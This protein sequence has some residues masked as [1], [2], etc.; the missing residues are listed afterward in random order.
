MRLINIILLCFIVLFVSSCSD[1]KNYFIDQTK[2]VVNVD[3]KPKI[4]FKENVTQNLNNPIESSGEIIINKEKYIGKYIFTSANSLTLLPN[5]TFLPNNNYKITFDFEAINKIANANIKPKSFTMEFSTNYLELELTNADFI[6]DS[7]DLSKI[8]LDAIINISQIVPIQSLKDNIKLLNSKGKNIEINI[9]E[10]DNKAFQILS[11]PLNIPSKNETYKL[12]IDKSLGLVKN[13]SFDIVAKSIDGLDIIDIKPILDDN[14]SIEVRFSAPLKQNLNLNNFIKISPSVNFRVS[15]LNDKIIINGNFNKEQDYNLEILQGI[16][17]QDNLSLAKNYQKDIVFGSQEPKIVFSNN[18]VFLPDS[19][20]KKI[21]FKSINVKKAKVVVK[22]IYANNIIRYIESYS[23]LKN[24]T[25]SLYTYDFDYMGSIVKESDIDIDYKKNIWVQNE[26]DLSGIKDLSGIF[27]VS[28]HFDKDNVDYKF[29]SGTPEWKINDYF[30]NNGNVYR[31]L[32]FS[33]IA[34][35]AQKYGD[36][37]IVSALDIKTNSPLSNVIIDGISKNNQIISSSKTDKN[38]NAILKYKGSDELKKQEL[39]YIFAKKQDSSNDLALIKLS[40][41]RLPDDGFDTEGVNVDNGIKA[42]IYTDRGVYR[43]GDTIN[44]NIIARNNKESLKH[45]IKLTITNPR[46]KKQI[47]NVILEPISD[48]MFYYAFQTQKNA[49]TGIYNV[50]I[51]IG[52]NIFT[53]KIAL[54]SVVPNRIKVNIDS[55]NKIDLSQNS[56]I[57]LTLQSEYLFGA[58]ASNLEYNITASI[59]PKNFISKKYKD[60]SFDNQTNLR[61]VEN[62][63]FSGSLNENGYA[64]N[65]L[66]LKD[67][68]KIN[69]N[70]EANII[71]RVYENN[72]RQVSARKSVYIKRFDSFVGIKIPQTRYVQ[73]DDNINLNVVLLDE[74]ENHIANRKLEYTVYNNNYSWWWD[75]DNYNDYIRSIKTDK[76]TT[77]IAKGEITSKDSINNIRFKANA[78]GELLVEVRDTTNNQSASISLYA[79]SWGEPINADKITQLKIKSDKSKY[80]HNEEAVITFESTKNAKALVTISNNEEIIDRYFVDTNNIKTSINVKIDEKYAPNLYVS[81]FLLQ[82]YNTN[83]NDR[84]LRLYGVVPLNIINTK[85]KIDLNINASDE[86]LPNSTLD[87]E[88]SNNQNKQVTYTLAI[89]DEGIINLTNFKTPSPYD[90]FYAK[91]KYPIINY[92]TFDYIIGRIQGGVEKVYSIGG[93]E[94]SIGD[95]TKKQRDDKADRFKPVVY[96]IPPTKSDEFG[97]AKISFKVPAYLGSLRVMLIAVNNDS[98][99]SV[100]KDV[101]VSAPVVM[102]PTIPRS[103]KI[104]DNFK[105]GIEVIPIKDDVKNVK[106]NI[107]SKGIIGFDKETQSINFID[108]KP[109][110]IFFNGKVKE[111]IGIE[112]IDINLESSSFNMKDSTE[113]DIKAPN[114]YMIISKNWA[115]NKNQII[116]IQSPASF[117]KN[118]NKGKITISSSPLLGID[119]RLLWL[120]RYP[121]GCI[122]QTTSSVFPQLFI[123]KLSNA[124]FIDKQAII[125]NIN[126]GINRIQGFQTNDGGFSYWQGEGDSDK[127]GSNYAGHFLIMAKKQGYYINDEVFNRWLN[128]LKNNID[129]NDMYSLFLLSLSDNH[130]LGMMNEIYE[131]KLDRLSVTNK[132][133]LAASYKLAGFDDIANKITNNL[134]V[135]PNENYSYYKYSYGSELRNKAIILQAYKIVKNKIE[136][137]L[138]NKIKDELESNSWLSTQTISYA[139]MV[140]ADIKEESNKKGLEGS[141][142]INNNTQKFKENKEKITFDLNSGSAKVSSPN[143]IFVNY[144]WEGINADNKGDNIKNK[145]TLSREFV[146]FDDYGNEIPIDIRELKNSKSFYIKLKLSYLNNNSMELRNIALT[147][148]LPSSWEIENTRLNNDNEPNAVIKANSNITYTDIRDDKIMW[149]FDMYKYVVVYVKINAVTPGEYTL[150]PAYAEAMYDGSYQASTDSFR[151]KVLAK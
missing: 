33:N 120:I 69:K 29:K 110:T 87:I 68:N 104:N 25:S 92:D 56:K 113:I 116:D 41:Q 58:K 86:V 32:I 17:S 119:H 20:N 47:N 12:M 6:K 9:T 96:F 135:I 64:Q 37:V 147:Q 136:N 84:S 111:E 132:W 61:Y 130:Q 10:V 123:E 139:L 51:D 124:D 24:S 45:P 67:I 145:M 88:I 70:L 28:L 93:D 115:L 138:Y 76:N 52:D 7:T 74:N 16:K 1:D 5:E 14:A 66:N 43:P 15:Q 108:K 73:I 8:K 53:S 102:L 36:N 60:W 27:I 91:T 126:A 146:I 11:E 80:R 149:F 79:S 21:A 46:G 72:G 63:S 148:N 44:L 26:L 144:I 49:D 134:E 13:T 23:L 142:T 109:Q 59:T 81:V 106:V 18:G 42:F 82:N 112:H 54:E 140:L 129:S 31:E 75:Y 3:I 100:S 95:T 55:Q 128:Y 90:Y 125:N 121:Y 98:Y 22:R 117:I 137:D 97:K 19:G 89:V 151:V 4:S 99:G 50:S 48:G 78:R 83:D 38:G 105:I 34:L 62:E 107:K 35:I 40:S 39:F 118:S 133:L 65:I 2:G 114:P 85:S 94:D 30:Y 127:W 141:I 77:I 103:L 101:K 122:E 131:N 150:P 71:A 143:N 57:K